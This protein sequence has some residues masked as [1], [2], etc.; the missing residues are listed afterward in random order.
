MARE[1]VKQ[2]LPVASRFVNQRA[3]I[4]FFRSPAS[5]LIF[6]VYLMAPRKPGSGRQFM[7]HCCKKAPNSLKI[8]R[9]DFRKSA[10]SVQFSVLWKGWN[11]KLTGSGREICFWQSGICVKLRLVSH[12]PLEWGLK[13]NSPI[14]L[15]SGDSSCKPLSIRMR[16]ETNPVAI[17]YECAYVL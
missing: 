10:I 13:R 17:N 2:Q 15:L 5:L 11:Q 16:I 8:S 7:G 14:W 1:V 12:Y 4:C 6:A 3:L 9:L